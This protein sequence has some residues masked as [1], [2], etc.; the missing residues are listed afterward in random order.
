[1]ANLSL[2]QTDQQSNNYSISL[3]LNVRHTKRCAIYTFVVLCCS[4]APIQALKP[5]QCAY[6]DDCMLRQGKAKALPRLH[7]DKEVP[8]QFRFI[9]MY[10]HTALKWAYIHVSRDVSRFTLLWSE[11]FRSSLLSV[12]ICSAITLCLHH[13]LRHWF[14]VFRVFLAYAGWQR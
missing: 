13:K 5:R 1:M 3:R 6:I 4:L 8:R 2:T 7:E 9:D 10:P 12:S 11:A 14:V